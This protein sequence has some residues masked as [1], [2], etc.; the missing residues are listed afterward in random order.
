MQ[1]QA[2]L[3]ITVHNESLTIAEIDSSGQDRVIIKL[4]DCMEHYKEEIAARVIMRWMQT[5]ELAL[6]P[7]D[8]V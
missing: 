3:K 1:P 7:E 2:H 4:D 5:G 8:Q 6:K